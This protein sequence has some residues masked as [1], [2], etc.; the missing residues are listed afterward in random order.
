M[1]DLPLA[2][3][4][5]DTFAGEAFLS[6]LEQ[7][8]LTEHPVVALGTSAT[9]TEDE[10]GQASVQL[11]GKP[12]AIESL[13]GYTFSH[14]QLVVCAGAADIAEAVIPVAGTAGALVLDATPYSRGLG[15]V[16][17]VHPD[18]NPE[19]LMSLTQHG[20][21]AVP[22]DVSMTVAPV[23][24]ALGQLGTPGRVDMT[25]CFSV[26]SAG[27]DGVSEMATQANRLLN[28]LPAEH[29]V[30]PDQIS[31]NMLP[32]I[33]G[34]CGD[35]ATAGR[36][37]ATLTGYYELPV[38]VSSMITPVFYGQAVQ[39]R[40]SLD[41]GVGVHEAWEVLEGLQ[42]VRVIN[43]PEDM[44]SP[45]ALVSADDDERVKT[46]V[47]GLEV[48]PMQDNVLNMW[49][50]SDNSRSGSVFGAVRLYERLLTE[51]LR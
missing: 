46:Q 37:L 6:L 4:G 29:N 23:L 24:K 9:N 47:C 41:W 21:L 43:D 12:L 26:S 11:A 15:E 35:A 3:V 18:L 8:N 38:H 28:G 16:P 36:E 10:D 31:F 49:L 17:L 34:N 1:S 7:Y 22:G 45:V 51:F 14:G 50:M 48:S 44:L 32:A 30:F 20:V 42:Y 5:A 39:L 19:Q 40:V 2:L 25:C 33:A 27:R 13:S